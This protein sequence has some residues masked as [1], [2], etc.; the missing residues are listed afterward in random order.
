MDVESLA[1][2]AET[3][4]RIDIALVL[5]VEFKTPVSPVAV[6]VVSKVVAVSTFSMDDVSEYALTRHLECRK[7]KEVVA[8]VLKHHAM[9]PV[10]LG[11]VHE[12]P[13]LGK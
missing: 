4:G 3:V 12:C 1:D 13:A 8:A 10:L 9:T 2:R 7:L 6:P 11:S 5:A